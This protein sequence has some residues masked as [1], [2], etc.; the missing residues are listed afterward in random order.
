MLLE[1]DIT[2]HMLQ[3]HALKMHS[4]Q[5]KASK[6]YGVD[7]NGAFNGHNLRSLRPSFPLLRQ[8]MYHYRTY[9]IILNISDANLSKSYYVVLE[10]KR[11]NGQIDV[12]PPYA[13]VF[14]FNTYRNPEDTV[15]IM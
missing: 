3:P 10:L 12:T 15:R 13:I 14:L 11:A 9:N 7:L 6:V 4:G 1:N 2:L 8:V 5:G